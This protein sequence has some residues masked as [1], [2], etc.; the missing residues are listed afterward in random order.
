M[1]P[2]LAS[3]KQSLQY[4]P[5]V[6]FTVWGSYTQSFKGLGLKILKRQ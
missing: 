1:L 6:V 5:D 4:G 3:L 2:S